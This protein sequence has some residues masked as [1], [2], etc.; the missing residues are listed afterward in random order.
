[1]EDES[2]IDERI[3]RLKKQKERIQTQKALLFLK[4][5]KIILE[6]KFSYE[7]AL[8]ILSHSWKPS[9][10]KQKE[11]WMKSAP[12]FRRTPRNTRKG[13]SSQSGTFEDESSRSKFSREETSQPAAENP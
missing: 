12:T 3:I 9:T 5:A 10:D 2:L 6:D 11:E 13:S 4:G 8:S 7:L 1:M